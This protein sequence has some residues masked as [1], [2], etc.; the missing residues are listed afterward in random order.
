MGFKDVTP[1]MT[2][3]Q[4]VSL[5]ACSLPSDALVLGQEPDVSRR[6][7]YGPTYIYSLFQ[8]IRNLPIIYTYIHTYIHTYIYIYT[9]PN[10]SYMT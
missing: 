2:T 1:T 3:Q 7:L 6:P 4:S 10:N 9:S 5:F 8:L